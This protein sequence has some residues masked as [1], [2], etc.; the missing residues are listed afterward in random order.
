M[1][2]PTLLAKVSL[3]LAATIVSATAIAVIGEI[4][5][6]GEY[7][8]MP[9][10]S[11]IYRLTEAPQR[12]ELVPNLRSVFG[13]I[14]TD[15]HGLRGLNN[16]RQTEGPV[17]TILFVGDSVT[18]AGEYINRVNFVARLPELLHARAP[19]DTAQ[20]VVYNGG[21]PGYTPFNELYWLKEHGA[22]LR[23][24]LVVVQFCA[25]DIVD[26]LPHWQ[27]F[28]GVG[29]DDRLV[30]PGAIPDA[31][32]HRRLM[33]LQPLRHLRLNWY[34]HDLLTHSSGPGAAD[35]LTIEDSLR[36]D[37]YVDAYSARVRWLEDMYRQLIATARGLGSKVLILVVPLAYQ[38]DAGSPHQEPQAVMERIARDNA[39]PL[40]DLTPAFRTVGTGTFRMDV[41]PR[42][43][44]IWHLSEDG[45]EIAAREL[46][47]AIDG[48]RIP[49]S[50]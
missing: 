1:A 36:L 30:P 20:T 12:Y 32:Y 25:N 43:H 9:G 13:K 27:R 45:H 33:L 46:A 3:A 48:M 5:L 8:P 29:F 41:D 39:V 7:G 14:D 34:L 10:Q 42:L 16:G 44:D 24:D 40:L 28:L 4:A 50:R 17:R 38:L 21:V 26:P 19:E 2:T 23:P 47:R 37:A 49:P 35:Y 15:E 18:F 11:P 22:A 31:A 6:R